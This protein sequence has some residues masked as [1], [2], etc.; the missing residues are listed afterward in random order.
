M[1]IKN[2]TTPCICCHTTLWNINAREQAINNKLQGSVATYLRRGAEVNNQIKKGLLLSLSVWKLKS[3]NICQSYKREGGCLVCF[4]R[5]ATTLAAKR[6]RIFLSL[7]HL[8]CHIRPPLLLNAG[9]IGVASYVALWH[10]PLSTSSN[11]FLMLHFLAIKV[12]TLWCQ[13][14]SGCS[15]PQLLWN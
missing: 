12:G 10:V 15:V 9:H 4:V 7:T 13:M 1:D 2:P 8:N 5:L 6:R 14:C 11:L 3:V